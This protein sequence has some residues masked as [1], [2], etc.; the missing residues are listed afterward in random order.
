[1]TDKFLKYPEGIG[2]PNQ[3]VERLSDV[4]DPYHGQDVLLTQAIRPT[5]AGVVM[6]ANTTYPYADVFWVPVYEGGGGEN[7]WRFGERGSLDSGEISAPPPLDLYYDPGTLT[8]WSMDY[9]IQAMPGTAGQKAKAKPTFPVGGVLQE[10][11]IA[12][13]GCNAASFCSFTADSEDTIPTLSWVFSGDVGIH[14]HWYNI[15]LDYVQ[16]NYA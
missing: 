12:A 11:V 10:S 9:G 15:R 13:A 1:M 7:P 6:R 4:V 16:V 5:V 14:K 8:A 2:W 3:T